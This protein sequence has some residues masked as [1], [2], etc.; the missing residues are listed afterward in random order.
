MQNKPQKIYRKVLRVTTLGALLVLPCQ[1]IL[2]QSPAIPHMRYTTASGNLAPWMR[3][4]MHQYQQQADLWTQYEVASTCAATCL[5][6]QGLYVYAQSNAESAP[7]NIFPYCCANMLCTC[8]ALWS[9]TQVQKNK[10]TIK[11]YEAQLLQKSAN[12]KQKTSASDTVIISPSCQTA[13][14]TGTAHQIS[15]AQ[16]SSLAGDSSD[17]LTNCAASS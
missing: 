10:S 3:R 12:L 16:Q 14:R 11:P 5:S 9:H 15:R 13:R 6:L 7:H 4:V 1:A 8:I 2:E 17:E